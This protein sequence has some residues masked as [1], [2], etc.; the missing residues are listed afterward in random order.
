MDLLTS[1]TKVGFFGPPGTFTEEALLTQADLAACELIPLT[2]VQEVLNATHEGQ[3]SVGFVPL[4][5]SIEGTVNAT[6]DALVFD[7]DLFIQREVIIPIH[8][9][10]LTF[11]EAELSDIESVISFPHAS[12]QCRRFLSKALP[13]AE[14]LAANSTAD[15]ARLVGNNKDP[16]MAAIAPELSAALYGLVVAQRAIEDHADDETK[17]VA[18][19]KNTIPAP[20]GHDR[21]TI[22]CFQRA[23]QPGNLHSILGE[24]SARGINLTKLESRPTKKALGE[25]CFIVELQGHL[26]DEVVADALI[27]LRSELADLKF[28][29]SYPAEGEGAS[30][31]REAAT[32]SWKAASSWVSDLR[33]RIAAT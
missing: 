15:A 4:E 32:E 28:L 30:T 31:L 25:Y 23:D 3:V 18:V 22:V 6:I 11:G 33:S 5:N 12:A 19:A 24:F 20:S 8:L 21:T 14:I 9:H 27:A 26:A 10:L 16:A 2:T 7:T 17:F 29:G 1:T 13:H